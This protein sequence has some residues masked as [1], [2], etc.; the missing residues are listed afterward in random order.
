MKKLFLFI[1]IALCLLATSCTISQGNQKILNDAY[2][3]R[4]EIGQTI[5]DVIGLIGKATSVLSNKS[6]RGGEAIKTYTW[7]AIKGKSKL[8]SAK[9]KSVSLIVKVKAGKVIDIQKI[10]SDH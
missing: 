10:E 4:V 2:T 7:T 1:T 6:K 5:T 3:N 9:A 8:Y